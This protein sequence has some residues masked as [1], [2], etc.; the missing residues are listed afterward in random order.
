MA[1]V[2]QLMC[3]VIT[4]IW[5]RASCVAHVHGNYYYMVEGS[6]HEWLMCTVIT[7]MYGGGEPSRVAINVHSKYSYTV[8][9]SPH[10][11]LMCGN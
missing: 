11:W 10:V 8:E 5:W 2:W 9:G 4:T 3:M 1:H 6:P 7:T